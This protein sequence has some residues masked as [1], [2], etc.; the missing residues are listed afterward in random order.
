MIKTV[1]KVDAMIKEIARDI[2]V[3]KIGEKIPTVQEYSTEFNM[4]V[5]TI[6]KAF[7]ILVREEVFEI[8]NK[9]LYGKFLLNKDIKKILR[10][11]EINELLAVMPLPK[12]KRYE[13][14][15][16]AI[17]SQFQKKGIKLH[18]AYMQGSIIRLNMVQ[19]NIYDF[20]IVSKLAYKNNS[21]KSLK[22][23]LELGPKSYV[24]KHVLIY[25][26]EIKK[27]GID[28]NSE[29]QYFLTKKI[30]ENKNYELVDIN[31]DSVLNLINNKVIDGAVCS[32]DEIEE[33]N[34][35]SFNFKNL[36]IIEKDYANEAVIVCNENNKLISILL[37]EIIDLEELLEIQNKVI[38]KE[39]IPF[40]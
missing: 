11:A 25:K 1:S 22:K 24:S 33:N 21:N 4:S 36:D 20:A 13:G 37:K 2:F 39:I 7:E 35:S 17:K 40:Y 32:Y 10:F 23:I 26:N 8:E 34:I 28:E 15:A 38:N 5:G 3:L 31:S 16:T 9:G 18:F 19:D 6:Q 29:D 12:T 14:I 27:I 30:I